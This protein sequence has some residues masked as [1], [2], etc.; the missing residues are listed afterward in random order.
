MTDRS[1]CQ[2][3]DPGAMYFTGL[4]TA[5]R[6]A[7]LRRAR[8]RSAT[9]TIPCQKPIFSDIPG[10]NDVNSGLPLAKVTSNGVKHRAKYTSI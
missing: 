4:I 10:K 6:V 9:G 1:S 2:Q 8:P 3:K 7:Q 5:A